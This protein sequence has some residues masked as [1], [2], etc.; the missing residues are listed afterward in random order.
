MASPTLLY[1]AMDQDIRS[2]LIS[3]GNNTASVL[4][5][6]DGPSDAALKL[7]DFPEPLLLLSISVMLVPLWFYIESC[8]DL[9]CCQ[10]FKH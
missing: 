1:G 6:L 5:L 7:I 3:K 10:S 8:T 9:H 2:F 4:Y